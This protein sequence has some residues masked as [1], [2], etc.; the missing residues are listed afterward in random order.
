V[1]RRL[2][3]KNEKNK[4]FFCFKLER[5]KQKDTHFLRESFNFFQKKG[6]GE[7]KQ[8]NSSWERFYFIFVQDID[9]EK[10]IINVPSCTNYFL[11][12]D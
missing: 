2:V 12:L 10:R 1:R 4:T 5:I 7:W 9:N 6:K 11:D 3:K 8:N